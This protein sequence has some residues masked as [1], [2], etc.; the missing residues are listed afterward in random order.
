MG[1]AS[2]NSTTSSDVN[3]I[4]DTVAP[5][6]A[7]VTPA[8]S[9]SIGSADD[10]ATYAVSGTCSEATQTVSIEIG[11]SAATSPVGFVCD[12][13]NFAGAIDTTGT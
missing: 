3:I 7:M 12:G 8:N 11:G 6:I 10:S 4:K 13:T 2:G 9:S 1:D 5:T